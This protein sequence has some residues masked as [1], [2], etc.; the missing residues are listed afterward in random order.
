[1]T[2]NKMRLHSFR[3]KIERKKGVLTH[4]QNQKAELDGVI[5][6]ARRQVAYSEDAQAIIHSVARATQDELSYRISDAAS[7]GLATVFDKPYELDV[8]FEIKRKQTE[9]KI[10]FKRDG[11]LIDPKTASGIGA[12]DIAAF[13]LQ[14]AVF[15]ISRPSPR[16]ILILD[17]PFKHL[18]GEEANLR[19]L[20]LVRHM[21]STLNIQIIMVSDERSS[22]ESIE[23]NCD[24]LFSIPNM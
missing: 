18:K 8:Q 24:K 1:M 14:I 21:S 15:S 2:G 23:E 19:A 16:N 7:L 17:E 12:V 3:Q 6:K 10:Q 20:Q 22:R 4:L 11:L 13:C 9:C 5:I